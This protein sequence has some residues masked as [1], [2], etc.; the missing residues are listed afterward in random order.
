VLGAGRHGSS[1]STTHLLAAHCCLVLIVGS[2]IV[3]SLVVGSLVVGSL[4]I[5]VQLARRGD[6][7]VDTFCAHNCATLAAT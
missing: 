4:V 5:P 3:G 6:F 2:L 7:V 1:L